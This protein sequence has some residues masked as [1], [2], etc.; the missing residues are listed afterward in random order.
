MSPEKD[1]QFWADKI[2]KEILTRKRFRFLNK[3][4]PDFRTYTVKTSAS[5]SGVLHIGRLSDTI[6]G[7]SVHKA[8]LD[9]G[10]RSDFIW[11]AEDMDPLRKIPK[12]VPGRYSEFIGMP[13]TDIPDP[14]GC[15]ES[16]AE[17]HMSEYMHAI[18]KFVSSDMKVFSMRKEYKLSLIHI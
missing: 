13:V 16:Y 2:A 15:H 8:L 9:M 7:E 18:R 17:H 12:G 14:D 10:A 5:L 6:R 4:I 3:K 1:S 11:V